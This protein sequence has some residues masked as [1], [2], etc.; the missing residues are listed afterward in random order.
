MN[1]LIREAVADDAEAIA[2][3]MINGMR[4]AFQGVVPDRCLQWPDSAANWKKALMEGFD[5][6]DFLV[7][8]Q[9]DDGKR[10]AYALGGFYLDDPNY[11][12]E[13]KQLNVLPAYHRQGIGGLLLRHVAGRLAEDGIYSMCVKVMRANPY[14]VF[15]E[16]LGGQYVSEHPYD[17]DGVMMSECLYGW[18]DTRELVKDV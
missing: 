17:W 8:A 14:R 18:Q 1:I 9:A 4:S 2:A 11:R 10:I 15:Y 13:L 12:G 16:R 3:V 7:V 6:G 5:A